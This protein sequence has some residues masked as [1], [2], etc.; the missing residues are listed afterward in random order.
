MTK[1]GHRCITTDQLE[2]VRALAADAPRL[3]ELE[4]CP[5]CRALLLSFDEF[6]EDRSVPAA[7]DPRAAAGALRA[8][9][10]RALDGAAPSG[11]TAPTARIPARP[12]S[13]P[14][15]WWWRAWNAPRVGWAFGVVLA[16]AAGLWVTRVPQR[17]ADATDILRADREPAEA[18]ASERPRLLP[19]GP[20]AQGLE[21]RWTRT[22]GADS[23]RVV[24]LDESL[25][26]VAEFGPMPDTTLLLDR[27][28]LRRPLVPGRRV[29]W[30]VE[31]LQGEYVFA[32]SEAAALVLP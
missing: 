15:A 4:G 3:L 2:G 22:S 12:R 29:A 26:R 9:F 1:N 23:Y 25:E 20:T 32:T 19:A 14:A 30:Q 24:L 8:A 5:R 13:A 11:A 7:A 10:E 28:R 6:L 18:R 21:L 17:G 31:A 16:V 27:T